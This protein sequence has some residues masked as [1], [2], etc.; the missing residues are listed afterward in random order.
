MDAVARPGDQES[1]P[2]WKIT[3]AGGARITDNLFVYP[4]ALKRA[5]TELR[6]RAGREFRR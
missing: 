1:K 3:F 4:A 6:E 2:I 5:S